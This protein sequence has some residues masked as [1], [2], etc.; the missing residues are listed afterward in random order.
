[1]GNLNPK[2]PSHHEKL[3]NVL[4]DLN[5]TGKTQSSGSGINEIPEK[6]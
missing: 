3:V 4:K 2:Q 1:M 6:L 5:A